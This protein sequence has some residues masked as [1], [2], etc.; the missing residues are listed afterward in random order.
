MKKEKIKN[1][2]L[3]IMSWFLVIIWMILIFSMSNM[4]S[5]ESSSV[6]KGLISNTIETSYEIGNK[7]GIISTMPSDSEINNLVLKLHT[8]VRKLAHFI[9]YLILGLLVCNAL[10]VSGV[11]NKI[12][13]YS[14]LICVLYSSIDEL[15][16]IFINGRA[17]R[18]TDILIDAFGSII[19]ILSYKKLIKMR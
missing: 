3:I 17:G 18:V 11:D 4:N 10:K 8:P 1:T 6:S 16:Q 9:E 13:L 14:I 5:D 19:G 2:I 15:H 12:I 7:V